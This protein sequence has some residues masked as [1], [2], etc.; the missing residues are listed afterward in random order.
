MP[1]GGPNVERQDIVAKMVD[2]RKEEVHS[3]A[4]EIVSGQ[5]TGKKLDISCTLDTDKMW[6]FG[7]SVGGWT[8][9][10]CAMGD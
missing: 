5:M 3:L 6:I 1:D 4:E 7:H 2:Q 10:W 9:L 8:S